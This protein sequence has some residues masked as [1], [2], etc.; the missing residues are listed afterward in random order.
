MSQ[1]RIP[2]NLWFFGMS[3]S[4]DQAIGALCELMREG[5][6]TLDKEQCIAYENE[7]WNEKDVL[8]NCSMDTLGMPTAQYYLLTNLNRTSCPSVTLAHNS[9][10]SI[11]QQES[12]L[13]IKQGGLMIINQGVHCNIPG[14][15]SETMRKLFTEEFLSMAE[16]NQWKIFY[17]ETERQHFATP[18]GYHKVGVSMNKCCAIQQEES[19]F[20]NKE[21]REFLQNL[22][23]KSG[24]KNKS[25]PIIPLGRATIPLYFMHGFDTERKTYDCTHYVYCPWRFELTWD[26]ILRGLKVLM[27]M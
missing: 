12:S 8:K 20:R 25:I 18:N 19:D 4:G 14:C 2:C 15:V 3:L 23:F 16:E 1:H 5:S 11:P 26:G 27:N 7:R 6:Y 9:L 21:A 10:K 13:Y 24:T 17:R 22:T